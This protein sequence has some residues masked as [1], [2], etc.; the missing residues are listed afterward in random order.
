MT[1]AE[2][3]NSFWQSSC[4]DVN[5]IISLYRILGACGKALLVE[6]ASLFTSDLPCILFPTRADISRYLY[7]QASRSYKR[8][9]Q[10]TYT[11]YGSP[12]VKTT[13][14]DLIRISS[15]EFCRLRYYYSDESCTK[16]TENTLPS[17]EPSARSWRVQVSGSGPPTFVLYEGYAACYCW[18]CWLICSVAQIK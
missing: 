6:V 2:G 18:L 12:L 3:S 8:R 5:V 1:R 17:F 13:P 15:F 4:G 14:P 10:S 16:I 7:G 11:T 9:T